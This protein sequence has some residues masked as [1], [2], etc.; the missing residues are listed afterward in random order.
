MQHF[1]FIAIGGAVMHQLASHLKN[2]GN[3]ITGSDDA[4]YEPAKSNLE[5]LGL[6]PEQTGWFPAKITADIDAIILGMHAKADN[7]ELVKAQELGLKI[8]SF[9]EFVFEQCKHKTRIAVA[10]SHGKTSI[11]SMI[12]HMLRVNN[13][14]FDYLVGA[15]LDGFD[16]MVKTSETAPLWSLKQMNTLLRPWIY[17]VNSCITIRILLL[18]R[19]LP[20]ITLMYFQRLMN[21]WKPSGNLF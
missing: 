16:F 11:T 14:E 1:H 15:K 17:E 4:I 9:P 2:Q 19:V 13:K 20:G 18:F 21:T 8:Y 5:K 12:M 7:P 10:G 3:T 6:M